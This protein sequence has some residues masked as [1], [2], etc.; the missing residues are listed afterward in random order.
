MTIAERVKRYVGEHCA[1]IPV[2]DVRM[3][4]GYTGVLLEDGRC[5][6]AFTFKNELAH[7][8][9]VFTGKRPLKGKSSHE[10]LEYFGAPSLLE[11]A[12]GLSVVNALVND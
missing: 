3:G 2:A 12:L 1:E 5:G 9:S 8:C 4:L 7:G 6:V 11:S 10:I